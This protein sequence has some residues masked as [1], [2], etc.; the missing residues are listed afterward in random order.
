MKGGG[1]AIGRPQ[2][3]QVK[4]NQQKNPVR[5][6]GGDHGRDPVPFPECEEKMRQEIHGENQPDRYRHAR[7]NPAP[8]KPNP[9]WGGHDRDDETGPGK[10]PPVLELGAKWSEERFGEISVRPEIMLQFR[11]A[12][13]LRPDI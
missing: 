8:G 9:E 4:P 12:E 11:D 6:P 2:V 3:E 1:L 7:Q 13:K 5:G 10:R